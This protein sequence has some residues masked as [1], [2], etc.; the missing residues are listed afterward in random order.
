MACRTPVIATKAGAAPELVSQGSGIL[1]DSRD[2]QEMAQAIISL[3]QYSHEDWCKMSENAYRVATNY[4]WDDA[5]ILFEAAL[6][7]AID[8]GD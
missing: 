5:T 8:Q 4:S 3:V 6:Q 7:E 1:L 2:P